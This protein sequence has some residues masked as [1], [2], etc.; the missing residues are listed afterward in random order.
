MGSDTV[1]GGPHT[2]FCDGLVSSPPIQNLKAVATLIG[3]APPATSGVTDGY[4][5]GVAFEQG[6]TRDEILRHLVA[7][8]AHLEDALLRTPDDGL[9]RSVPFFGRRT[10]VR[11][12][13]LQTMTHLHEH[14]GQTIAYARMNGV[15]PPWS[16]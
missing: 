14:L 7:S 3:I 16:N 4:Q 2:G 8:F 9:E 12:V 5:S 1:E 11:G 6:G 10:S 13:W 15:T